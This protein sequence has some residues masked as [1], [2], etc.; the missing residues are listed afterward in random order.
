MKSSI[1]F[2]IPLLIASFVILFSGV[3]A[4]LMRMNWQ[5]GL[6]KP[7][8]LISHGYLMVPGFL[9]TLIG[10]E[11]AVALQKKW[12]YLGPLASAIGTILIINQHDSQIGFLLIL[13]G[14]AVMTLMFFVILRTHFVNYM[15][16]MALGGI[17]LLVGNLLW[18]FGLSIYQFVIWWMG[19][20]ILT[21][22]GERLELGRLMKLNRAVKNAFS[23][24]IIIFLMGAITSLF[25][26]SAGQKIA[27]SAMILLAVWLFQNDIARK[28]IRQD[29]LPKF[30]A[31][32]LLSGY[33]WLF[34][35]GVLGLTNVVLFAGPVYDAYLHSVFLGFVMSMIFAHAPIILPAII[36]T[37][38]VI[39]KPILYLPLALLHLSLVIRILGDII[40]DNHQIRQWGGMLNAIAILIYFGFTIFYRLQSFKTKKNLNI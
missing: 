15:I 39:F 14:S 30:I 40:L 22:A 35:G 7:S 11:R 2:R 16:T 20:L 18:G 24:I 13:I 12:G 23:I 33:V 10:L 28:T 26:I 32:C 17:S 36:N 27:S 25:N 19:F 9:G 31:I 1:K 3:W 29:G 5:L 38:E 4:G 6:F 34:I 37:A 8:I 21:I